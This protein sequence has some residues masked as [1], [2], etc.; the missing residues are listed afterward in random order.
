MEVSYFSWQK[1]YFNFRSS[2]PEVFCKKGALKNFTKSIGKHLC[3][4]LFFNKVAGLRPAT[5]LKKRLWH[6]C[7]PV[8]FVRFLWTPFLKEHLWWLLLQL[9]DYSSYQAKIFS[10][11]LSSSLISATRTFSYL[12]KYLQ[13]MHLFSWSF[14]QTLTYFF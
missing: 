11:K 8:S 6:R 3:Q 12:R 7:F 14:S 5:L 10:Y 2:H 4:S 13:L 9:E 1:K